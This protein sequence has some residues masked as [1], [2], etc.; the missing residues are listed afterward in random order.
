MYYTDHED[1]NISN[2]Q[3][4]KHYEFA[5]AEDISAEDAANDVAQM[6]DVVDIWQR[7]GHKHVPFAFLR[8]T[9]RIKKREFISKVL[10]CLCYNQESVTV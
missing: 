9:V 8:Q 7:T 1:I 6:G 10:I 2:K 5:P 3:P 4:K